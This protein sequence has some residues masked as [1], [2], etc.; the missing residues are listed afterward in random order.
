MVHNMKEEEVGGAGMVQQE[1]NYRKEE[2]EGAGMVWQE[3]L[4]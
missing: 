2:V 4:N 3:E 1:L